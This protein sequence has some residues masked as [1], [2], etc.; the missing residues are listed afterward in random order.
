[1]SY[2]NIV[3]SVGFFI[4]S[5][6]L[7]IIVFLVYVIDKKGM[8]ESHTQYRLIASNAENI[9]EGMP[10]LFSGF[11]VGQVEDLGLY[12]NGEVLVTIS[13]PE[14]NKKW[15]RSDA[16]FLLENPLIG[17]AKITLR[18][19]INY[20]PLEEKVILRMQIKDGIN[21]IITNIQ[22]VI[23]ELQNIVSNINALSDS[24]ADKNASFQTSLKHAETFSQRL[25]SSPN[26]LHT[27]T[28]D[29]KSASRL[30]QAISQLNLALEDIRSLV[31]NTDKGI[32]EIR[33]EVV[34]PANRSI[35]ELDLIF[36]D[37]HQKLQELD[38]TVKAIGQ[39]D[40]DI[41]YFKD[42]M[43]RLLDEANE[44][45]ARLN[46]LIGEEPQENIRLP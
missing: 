36:K 22:P 21:E 26:L 29:E 27:V 6:S 23:L 40:K 5:T 41:K 35:E 1:M 24:L 20:P 13:I 42:E 28:G 34:K 7:L 33:E 19:S 39:S 10:I 16:R 11:E 30:H 43:K 38:G 32:S 12:E 18:S 8:F 14:H 4:L 46:S 45:S 17:K 15:L 2:R 9:E 37:I 44:I 31:Q 3:L 25:A